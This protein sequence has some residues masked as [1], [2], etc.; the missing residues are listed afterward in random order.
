MILCKTTAMDS[1]NVFLEAI[2]YRLE[3]DNHAMHRMLKVLA[4][5]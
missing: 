1:H 3:N 2:E 5:F 4:I